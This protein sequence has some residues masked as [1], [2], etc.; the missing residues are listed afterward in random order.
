MKKYIVPCIVICI[1]ACKC[2]N[3]NTPPEAPVTNTIANIT[4][5]V[6]NTFP[7]DAKDFTEGLE[8]HGGLM[9]E[10]TGNKGE[11][12]IKKYEIATNKTLQQVKIPD[13]FFG[14][15]IT[16]INNKIYQLTY[17]EN[18][19]FVYELATFKKIKEFAWSFGEGWGLTNDGKQLIASTGG[20]QLYF[21]DPE[22]FVLNK[23]LTVTGSDGG[24][25]NM[26]NELEYVNGS[27]YANQYTTNY[28]F[29]INA[30]T[31]AITGRA[32]LTGIL[33]NN[34]KSTQGIDVLNGIAYDSTKQSFYV[35]GKYWPS[36]F[37]IK[38]N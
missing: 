1:A 20:S 31:G 16:I 9:F 5:S 23:T 36:L 14:E 24:P 10:G 29:K 4:Y 15:G 35:T 37:E 21:I 28:I 17:Q 22:T 34:N 38:F 19:V 13:E 32:D 18:K 8:I 33:Q 2:G 25:V 26:I 12:F 6:V 30:E 11:S 27:I 3:N 7:H